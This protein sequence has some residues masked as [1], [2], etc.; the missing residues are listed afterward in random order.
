MRAEGS[1]LETAADL[2]MGVLEEV[3]AGRGEQ[4]W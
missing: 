3:D 2:D 4:D 1:F